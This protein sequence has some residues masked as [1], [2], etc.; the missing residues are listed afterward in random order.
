MEF[1]SIFV[2]T[3]MMTSVTEFLQR[4]L[5]VKEYFKRDRWLRRQFPPPSKRHSS[6][7]ISLGG[8]TDRKNSISSKS[9]FYIFIEMKGEI[10]TLSAKH[11]GGCI[12][13]TITF[14]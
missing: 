7:N 10:K 14:P 8:K 11:K 1:L 3:F 13:P 9:A 5:L 4:T 12:E 2:L 6:K